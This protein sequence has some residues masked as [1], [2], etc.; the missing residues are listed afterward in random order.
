MSCAILL[1]PHAGYAVELHEIDV[2]RGTGNLEKTLL[3]I[4]NTGDSELS[5]TAELAHWYSEPVA[6]IAAGSTAV[7]DLWFAPRTGTFALLNPSEDNMPVERLWCGIAG[8]A[9]ETRDAL[10]LHPDAAGPRR[11]AC[12]ASE[13]RVVC[14]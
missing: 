10:P 14:E 5:C 13:D 1:F 6:T 9:Y 3:E 7:I 12:A 2:D 8:R 11:I 4:A